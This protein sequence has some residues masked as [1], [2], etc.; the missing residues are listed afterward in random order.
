VASI[1][2]RPRTAAA[3]TSMSRTT[4]NFPVDGITRLS[5]WTRKSLAQN[6]GVSLVTTQREHVRVAHQDEDQKYPFIYVKTHH[7]SQLV[8]VI[9]TGCGVISPDVGPKPQDL[10]NFIEANL[11]AVTAEPA[12][13]SRVD[14]AGTDWLVICTHCHFDHICGIQ[15]L[16]DAGA[17]IIASACDRDFINPEHCY[18][19]SLCAASGRLTPDHQISQFA[20]DGEMIQHRDRDLDLQLLHTPG[21]TPDSMAFYDLAERWLFVDDTVYE[22]EGAM[23]W[24]EEKMVSI[25]LSAQGDWLAWCAI[26]D[27]ILTSTVTV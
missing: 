14:S 23:P 5:Y 22:C 18:V 8:V 24:G 26:L 12:T 25:L 15:S 11:L 17:G 2:C 20:T 27:T 1:F 9:D 6:A 13:S 19:N 7:D 3:T 21:H 16:A 10:K 4:T